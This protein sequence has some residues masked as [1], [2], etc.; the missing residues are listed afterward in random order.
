MTEEER[1]SNSILL[2][3]AEYVG[4]ETKIKEILPHYAAAEPVK[5]TYECCLGYRLTT[6]SR[7]FMTKEHLKKWLR[8]NK[9]DIK[10]YPEILRKIR[11]QAVL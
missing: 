11:K 10:K 9:I 5:I 8:K 2:L 6:L 3:D 4:V 7:T 1:I